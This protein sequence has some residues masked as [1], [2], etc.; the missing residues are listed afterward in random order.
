[1]YEFYTACFSTALPTT[2]V[3]LELPSVIKVLTTNHIFVTDQSVKKILTQQQKLKCQ[4]EQLVD[5]LGCL[6]D[7]LDDE[8]KKYKNLKSEHNDLENV[9][10]SLLAPINA[11]TGRSLQLKDLQL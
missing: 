7:R 11:L 3:H 10:N 6:N 1:M 8:Y 9:I 2:N 5:E 4:R